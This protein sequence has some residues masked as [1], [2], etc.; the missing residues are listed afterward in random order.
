MTNSLTS[1]VFNENEDIHEGE[2]DNEIKLY[3]MCGIHNKTWTELRRFFFIEDIFI[4]S[5]VAGTYN[6]YWVMKYL[7]FW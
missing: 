2:S 6:T 4:L 7:L 3:M 1:H 5:V